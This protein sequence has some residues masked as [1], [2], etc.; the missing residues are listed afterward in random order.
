MGDMANNVALYDLKQSWQILSNIVR[1]CA[2]MS[3]TVEEV[4]RLVQIISD[5]TRLQLIISLLWLTESTAFS[6]FQLPR[7][8]ESRTTVDRWLLN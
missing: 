8:V 1:L 6:A 7:N 2:V 5:I 4:F 3:V